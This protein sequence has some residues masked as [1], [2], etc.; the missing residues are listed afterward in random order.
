[1]STPSIFCHPRCG[2]LY[3]VS[4]GCF[5]PRV[6][7]GLIDA[8]E[9]PESSAASSRF[10]LAPSRWRTRK[11]RNRAA[12]KSRACRLSRIPARSAEVRA[13]AI[14]FAHNVVFALYGKPGSKAMGILASIR[15][16]ASSRS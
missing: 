14:R 3:P 15:L 12:A 9:T 6:S 1:M 11:A 2:R 10:S 13:A 5:P 7:A 8:I 16:P 4:S